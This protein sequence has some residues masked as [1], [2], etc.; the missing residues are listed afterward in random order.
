[1]SD[2][3]VLIC[4]ANF[5]T[6]I[7]ELEKNLGMAEW[8]NSM[9]LNTSMVALSKAA[10]LCMH[11]R[12]D[13]Q[14]HIFSSQ[15]HWSL[16]WEPDETAKLIVSSPC[17]MGLTPSNSAPSGLCEPIT[18]VNIIW[19]RYDA[20]T[21]IGSDLKNHMSNASPLWSVV[22]RFVQHNLAGSQNW[23]QNH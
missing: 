8:V 17:Q 20:L 4:C 12:V 9:K 10:V 11:W 18:T 3:S 14:V 2:S 7:H 22:C 16:A 15:P 21:D 1:M 23:G 6:K 19:G 13:A 5:T